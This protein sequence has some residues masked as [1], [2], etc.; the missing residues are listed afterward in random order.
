METTGSSVLLQKMWFP[1]RD[2]LL[3]RVRTAPLTF[4]SINEVIISSY[5]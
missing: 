1:F 3:F 2:L 4:S 5:V